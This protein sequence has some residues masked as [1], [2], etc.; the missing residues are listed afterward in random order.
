MIASCGIWL[1]RFPV[2]EN[3]AAPA[4]VNPNAI[5]N[6][7]QLSRSIRNT[8]GR[9]L[10]HGYVDKNDPALDNVQP[11]IDQQPGQ[12]DASHDRPKHY[13]P[14]NYGRNTAPRRPSCRFKR[15][16]VRTAQ[17]AFPTKGDMRKRIFISKRQPVATP[18]CRSTART[19]PSQGDRRET[20]KNL[21]L[22]PR[23]RSPLSPQ[24]SDCEMARQ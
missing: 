6:V 14:H 2:I 11:E 19:S 16:L 12:N 20:A 9:H 5:A 1:A 13:L 24:F 17:R 10:C 23:S 3:I 22:S 21:R 8:K 18:K 4:N 15:D 7:V